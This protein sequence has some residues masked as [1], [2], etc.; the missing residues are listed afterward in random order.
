MMGSESNFQEWFKKN[1]SSL[2]LEDW[3]V[4]NELLPKERRLQIEIWQ[5]ED[6]SSP[7][8]FK[9]HK[10]NGIRCLCWID[11]KWTSRI[12]KSLNV[13]WTKLGNYI[14]VSEKTHLPA[15]IV[16]FT[17]EP[18]ENDPRAWGH[19]DQFGRIPLKDIATFFD[20]IRNLH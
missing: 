19:V 16:V 17:G 9:I 7:P 20:E 2:M 4:E 10:T 6:I 8:D 12:D 18:C 13:N 11:V 1:F 14:R 15:Y 3:R 5:K